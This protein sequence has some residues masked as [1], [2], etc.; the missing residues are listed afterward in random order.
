MGES[1][2]LREIVIPLAQ[3]L[4]AG[5]QTGIAAVNTK[6]Q[7]ITLVVTVRNQG[8]AIVRGPTEVP[9]GARNQLA[10]FPNEAPLSLNLPNQFT[11]SLWVEV[12]EADCKV[13]LTV[14]HQSPGV[15]TTFPAISLSKVFTP[16]T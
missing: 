9:L 6:D 14:I 15:L 10:R 11:G 12:K 2:A 4:A 1:F 7:P 3:D 8:G 16:A 5:I 13:A